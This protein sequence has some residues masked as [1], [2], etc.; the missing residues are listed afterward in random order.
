[1]KQSNWAE[2]QMDGIAG[3]VRR[4]AQEAGELAHSVTRVR[5]LGDSGWAKLRELQTRVDQLRRE[6]WHATQRPRA[7]IL[8]FPAQQLEPQPG[9]PSLIERVLEIMD[10]RRA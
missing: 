6:L 9:E 7:Q 8:P 3:A 2:K 10:R 5:A 4:I 1:M